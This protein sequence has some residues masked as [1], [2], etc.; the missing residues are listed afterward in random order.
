MAKARDIDYFEYEQLLTKHSLSNPERHQVNK[1]T[2][3][4]RYGIEISPEL[5][6]LDDK[7]YYGQLLI[8]YYLTHESEYFHVK[9][10]QEW[11]Q[12]L[13]W[14]EGKVFLPDLKTYTLRVEAMRA[15][16]V[17]QFLE[18]ERVFRE[19]DAD[20]IWL[21]N[22]ALQSSKHIKRALGID[23]VRGKKSVSGIKILNRLLGLLGLKLVQV[24]DVYQIDLLSLNDD[25]Q[26]IFAVWQQ[27]DDSMLNSLKNIQPEVFDIVPKSQL[28]SCTK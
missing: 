26:K 1:Y 5:K 22:V 4:Q 7:G 19:N 18:A 10:Q 13:F 8:H 17:L 28:S 6:L 9:D 3:K 23:L 20:L 11:N 21:K 2:L 14:G 24:N 12:Q 27:R 25:R 15:L 16:G